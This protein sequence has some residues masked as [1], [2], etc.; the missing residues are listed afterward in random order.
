M[1]ELLVFLKARLE[2]DE[3]RALREVE[4]K[5]EIIRKCELWSD[6][7]FPEYGRGVSDGMELAMLTIAKAYEGHP[8]YVAAW[9][10][11]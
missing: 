7:A 1:S 4:V 2:E 8:D 9:E 6:T 10:A 11:W 5:R 3:A